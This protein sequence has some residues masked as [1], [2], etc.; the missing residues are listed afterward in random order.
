MPAQFVR[1]ESPSGRPA[2]GVA[3]VK[4]ESTRFLWPAQRAKR[5]LPRIAE[6]ERLARWAEDSGVLQHV[7]QGC[8]LC[9]KTGW[10]FGPTSLGKLLL[11]LLKTVLE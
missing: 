8:A 3:L 10:T 11:A 5:P 9:W 7:Y 4:G 1:A 2:K 6:R